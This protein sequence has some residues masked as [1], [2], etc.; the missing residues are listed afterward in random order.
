MKILL[1]LPVIFLMISCSTTE[2]RSH[3]TPP[4][5]IS[6]ELY[7]ECSYLTKDHLGRPVIAWTEGNKET[8]EI[9]LYYAVSSDN[10]QSFG[11]PIK[12]DPSKGTVF[13]AESMNKVAFKKDGT[14]IAVFEKK[15][16]TKE[17]QY[18]GYIFYTQSF[19]GG[20]SWTD[21]EFLHTDTSSGISRSF[22][23]LAVLPD[24]EV[25]AIWLDGR[26][27]LGEKGSSVFFSSTK[28]K[29][30][31]Q[32]D[33]QIGETICQCCRTDLYTDPSGKV[34]AVFRDIINDS[35]RDMVH[36]VSADTARTF[37]QPVRISAD[38]WIIKGCPHTGP[39][40]T[41]NRAGL[42]FTWFTAGGNSGV[43]YC[44]SSDNGKTFKERELVSNQ[45]RHP[46]ISSTEDEV[47][48][49]WDEMI[50]KD[51]LYYPRIGIQ[52]RSATNMYQAYLS[53]E[54]KPAY[55]PQLLSAGN[56][57]LIVSWTQEENKRTKVVYKIVNVKDFK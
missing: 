5:T 2:Q 57:L 55:F 47:M 1:T 34:H 54:M 17:N 21:S 33:T 37:S 9:Y 50:R 29:E 20:K 41:S 3:I 11:A 26:M 32:K 4:V 40:M 43:Y 16:P 38:N 7:A 10:G 24:G 52:I 51:S 36:I 30:G 18:A 35:I 28:G 44:N 49:V 42:H 22:F 48:I 23:D 45:A 31:F 39:D 46:R 14:V 25:G 56:N 8:K 53:E 27:K 15:A 19:D 13:H 12:V 6:G